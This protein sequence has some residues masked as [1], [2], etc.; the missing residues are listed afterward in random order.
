MKPFS[1]LIMELFCDAAKR[2]DGQDSDRKESAQGKEDKYASCDFA[3]EEY[4]FDFHIF[5]SIS[6]L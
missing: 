5:K 3:A 6:I 1:T 4:H 2:E